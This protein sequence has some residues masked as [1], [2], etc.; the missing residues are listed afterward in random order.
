MNAT[1]ANKGVGLSCPPFKRGVLGLSGLLLAAI[2]IGGGLYLR[3][4][5][6]QARRV[7][8]RELQGIA[9]MKVGQIVAC[10]NHRLQEARFLSQAAFVARDVAAFLAAPDSEARRADTLHWLDLLMDTD[11]HA[12]VALFDAN[13]RERLA[14]AHWPDR[15]RPSL[16]AKLAEAVRTRQVIM[17]DLERES[18]EDAPH[19]DMVV[20]ILSPPASGGPPG[21]DAP[22]QA[23]LVLRLDPSRFLYP[24]IQSWPTSSPTAETLLVRREGQEVLFL[25]ELR[26]RSQTAL[27]LRLPLSL[28]NV[29]AVRGALGLLGLCEGEDYRG[30][31]VVAAICPVPDSSWLLVAKMD[32]AELY[33]PLRRQ[34]LAVG[35]GMAALALATLLGMALLWRHRDAAS[36]EQRL[37]AERERAALA[38]R[39]AQIMD[40]ANDIILLA[41][42]DGRILEANSQAVRAYG[43]TLEELR[44]MNLSD[45]Q[46]AVSGGRADHPPSPL[47]GEERAVFE[48]FHRRKDGTVLAV[49]VSARLVDMGGERVNLAI[50]RDITRRKEAEAALRYSQLKYHTLFETANDAILLMRQDRFVDCNAR[51]AAMFGCTRQ[52]LIQATPWQFSPPTQPDGQPSPEKAAAMINLALTEGPQFF[53]WEHCRLDGTRFAA[54]VSLNR[55]VLDGETLLLAIVRDVTSRK[56]AE[57]ALRR[58]GE[59]REQLLQ[60]SRTLARTLDLKTVLQITTDRATALA[61]LQSA[62]VY[63]L[64]GDELRLWATTPPMSPERP[65]SFRRARLADHP[66]IRN[67]LSTSAPI[68]L[69]D[70]ATAPLTAAER[71][72]VEARQLRT[73]L[74]LPLVAGEEVLGALIVGSVG[75]PRQISA[76]EIDLCRTM[77]NLAALAV[78][79]A[80]LYDAGQRHVAELERQVA[81]RRR[82]EAALRRSSQQLEALTHRLQAAREEEAKRIARELHDELGQL[83]TGLKMDLRQVERQLEGGAPP[84]DARGLLERLVAASELA[85]AAIRTVQRISSELRPGLLDKLGLAAALRYEARQFQH[86]TGL[87]CKLRVPE[88]EPQVPP[89]IATACYRVCQEALTN[90]IRHAAATEVE[91]ELRLEDAQNPAGGTWVLEVRDN[92][93]GIPAAKLD[94]PHSL[95]L[96]GM[97]ERARALGG[98]VWITAGPQGG[99]IVSLRIPTAAGSV[100][101]EP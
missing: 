77:A 62:A 13:L 5:Q 2:A 73:L 38:Q 83:L 31:P 98:T 4:V 46:S 24:L 9:D 65:D 70:A 60:I 99:T 91:I 56:Q 66:H 61:G 8:H 45:L 21:P 28:T 1:A 17:G 26:H 11:H 12:Q 30:V 75:A 53:E 100:G 7:A 51:A 19:L 93:Q 69:P 44:S 87:V 79:N 39:L 67:A 85:D 18:P 64:E 52:D 41:E 37:A 82:A 36:L 90:V 47:A 94:D 86:R 58:Q 35:G 25:N 40:N 78:A 29:P 92:G 23:V 33:A 80:R 3:A 34:A 88:P 10:R 72:V 63:L 27:A 42:A 16:Q 101:P 6:A 97:E 57:A 81:E 14:A 84:G 71:L 22:V 49:E 74:F 50:V 95:G 76:A 55:M 89:D 48:T 59:E 68:L 15:P 32:R 20:P 43:W 96:L 54:E